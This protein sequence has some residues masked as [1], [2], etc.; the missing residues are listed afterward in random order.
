MSSQLV[1]ITRWRYWVCMNYSSSIY[2]T[3]CTDF[4]RNG[5]IKFRKNTFL[6]CMLARCINQLWKKKNWIQDDICWKFSI[7]IIFEIIAISVFVL[8]ALFWIVSHL[9]G[10]SSIQIVDFILYLDSLR[11]REMLF[12]GTFNPFDVY[13]VGVLGDT[14]ILTENGKMKKHIFSISF[15]SQTS[16]EGKLNFRTS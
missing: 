4:V 12:S 8:S 2:Y 16:N 14:N 6:V 5:H 7:L 1:L 3:L 10:G 15:A 11:V 13:R 9:H